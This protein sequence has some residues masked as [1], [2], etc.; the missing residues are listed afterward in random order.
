MGELGPAGI[1][2]EEATPPAVSRPGS[3]LNTLG[4]GALVVAVGEGLFSLLQYL[5]QVVIGRG[6]GAGVLGQ[7]GLLTL[8]GRLVDTLGRAGLPVTNIRFIAHYLALG[9]VNAARTTVRWTTILAT[10]T[11]LAAGVALW[12]SAPFIAEY[13]YHDLALT[14]GFRIAAFMVPLT[15]VM[16]TMLAVP[17]AA[18]NAVPLVAISRVG[19]PFLALCGTVA[20]VAAKGSLLQL[21]WVQ[22]ATTAMGTMAAAFVMM[23]VIPKKASGSAG[24][25][26][27]RRIIKFSIVMSAKVVS[28]F[29][30]T[31]LDVII[32]G[33]FVSKPELGVYVAASRTALFILFPRRAITP[34]Y[35]PVVSEQFARKDIK[36]LEHTYCVSRRWTTAPALALF[37]VMVI[38]PAAIMR[39]NGP[40]FAVGGVVLALQGVAC[41][42]D[43]SLGGSNEVLVMT[44]GQKMATVSE[45][46]AVAVMVLTLPFFATRWGIVGASVS[47]LIALGGVNVARQLWLTKHVGFHQFDKQFLKASVASAALISGLAYAGIWTGDTMIS[48]VVRLLIFSAGFLGIMLWGW[49]PELRTARGL[50][51]PS[52]QL[53]KSADRTSLVGDRS[54]SKRDVGE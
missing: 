39:V 11:G 43:T 33:H 17:Q 23:R 4:M 6:L 42:L 7:F 15:V 19:V 47:R 45:W 51:L 1:S 24:E 3:A 27:L 38:A 50:R 10:L 53:L 31:S 2:V 22:V 48:N 36:A 9:Q 30:L 29:L 54:E 44:G 41:L 8:V 18:K 52:R 16:L 21:V 37:G 5:L 46:V 13:G 12:V 34:L 26:N 32:V 14:A 40:E 20:V 49:L 35:M 28:R 25:A